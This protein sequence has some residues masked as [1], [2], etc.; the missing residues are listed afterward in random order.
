M[1]MAAAVSGQEP[2]V[3]ADSFM[4]A[5]DL[6][7]AA[8]KGS[9]LKFN[10]NPVYKVRKKL[11]AAKKP[12][13]TKKTLATIAKPAT[14]LWGDV[15]VTIWRLSDA[16]NVDDSETA[17]L[18]TRDLSGSIT[19]YEGERVAAGGSFTLGDKV[20][21][22]IEVPRTGYLYVVDREVYTDGTYGE[23]Y[24]IFPTKLSRGGDNKVDAGMLIDIPAQSD[25]EPF[26]TLKASD[27]RWRG[28]LLSIIIT[29]EPIL[30]VPLPSRP[31]PIASK[32]VDA[33]ESKYLKQPILFEQQG[34][35]GKTYTIAERDAGSGKRQLTQGDPYPQTV[36]R[37]KMSPKEPVMINIDLTVK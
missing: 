2:A 9:A 17:K 13:T 34:T 21:V 37:V 4:R 7:S 6:T 26:F 5:R 18:L 33:W 8:L 30:E 24:L 14:D 28:E 27:P 1:F 15:G 19:Q 29:S 23:P 25:P 36:Y 12:K 3:T 11:T 35:A 10:K 16:S 20:R 31:S 22:S 32:L